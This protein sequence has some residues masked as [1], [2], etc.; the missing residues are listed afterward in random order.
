MNSLATKI[1]ISQPTHVGA[2]G[3]SGLM[4]KHAVWHEFR[5]GMDIMQRYAKHAHANTDDI[6]KSNIQLLHRS[7][8]GD[9]VYRRSLERANGGAVNRSVPTLFKLL[10]TREI[11]A[12]LISV[13]KGCSIPLASH[14]S[15][16][17]M[18]LAVSGT[19]VIRK[20]SSSPPHN[21]EEK[22]RKRHWWPHTRSR[23]NGTSCKAG[24][25]ML[26]PPGRSEGDRL[27]ALSQHCVIL[28][29]FL[30]LSS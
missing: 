21:H 29:V 14:T 11:Q 26:V 9:P 13:C 10:A 27:E 23:N 18:F 19:A 6:T 22:A 12:D 8:L 16:Q 20:R 2:G 4:E 7:L 24:D 17:A 25:V 1:K 3:E 5:A 28:S 30:P 15:S